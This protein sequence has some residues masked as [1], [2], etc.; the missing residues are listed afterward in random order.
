MA[1]FWTVGFGHYGDN[2]E[3]IDMTLGW[4]VFASDG[5]RAYDDEGLALVGDFRDF[6]IHGLD[7]HDYFGSSEWMSIL[8]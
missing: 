2:T 1:G 5:G 6:K 7:T 8:I 4:E 3:D